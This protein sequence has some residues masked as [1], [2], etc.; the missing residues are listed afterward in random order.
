ML[1]ASAQA[2]LGRAY[3]T[4]QLAGEFSSFQVNVPQL[5]ADVDRDKAKQLGVPLNDLFQTLRIY[6]GSAYVNDFN[7]FGRTYQVIAQADAPFRA[8][9]RG[10]RAAQG[11][12]HA[13]AR[14]CRLAPC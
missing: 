7:K 14:W 2:L 10:H 5:F 9:G 4:P 1:Y 6:L 3:Q 12:Q 8:I 11:S 13:A